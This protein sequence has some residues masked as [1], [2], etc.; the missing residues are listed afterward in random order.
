MGSQIKLLGGPFCCADIAANLKCLNRELLPA[1]NELLDA[2]IRTPSECARE[3]EDVLAISNNLIDL[4]NQ[5]RPHQARASLKALLQQS[6]DEKQRLVTTLNET[7]AAAHQAA[8]GVSLS[9]Q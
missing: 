5:L 2:L 7:S 8:S 6:I 3:Q 4:C 1:V 9:G